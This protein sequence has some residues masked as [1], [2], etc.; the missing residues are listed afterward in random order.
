[1]CLAK[2]KQGIV[3]I[4]LNQ[5]VQKHPSISVTSYLELIACTPREEVGEEIFCCLV[6]SWS[7]WFEKKKSLII[8][9]WWWSDTWEEKSRAGAM[10]QTFICCMAGLVPRALSGSF[11]DNCAWSS[12]KRR[13]QL[14][15]LAADICLQYSHSCILQRC[16][17]KHSQVIDFAKLACKS[18]RLN[19]TVVNLT[20]RCGLLSSKHSLPYHTA[21]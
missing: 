5:N 6:L 12:S 9:S 15:T 2:D 8:R 18:L 21:V 4:R 19:W 17:R 3:F 7:I 11:S 16:C 13:Q 10:S 1:M 20:P 14:L